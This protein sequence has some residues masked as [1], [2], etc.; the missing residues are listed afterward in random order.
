MISK[1]RFACPSFF[2][3]GGGQMINGKTQ[4]AFKREF[5]PARENK[6]DGGKTIILPRIFFIRKVVAND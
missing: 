1:I 4:N 6:S 5:S 3:C 2:Y